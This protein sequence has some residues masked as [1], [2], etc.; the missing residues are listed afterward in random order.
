MAVTGLVVDQYTGLLKLVM[1]MAY[2][3]SVQIVNTSTQFP[4]S[5]HDGCSLTSEAVDAAS[6]RISPPPGKVR[7]TFSVTVPSQWTTILVNAANNVTNDKMKNSLD[8]MVQAANASSD[9]VSSILTDVGL[10]VED[11][12]QVSLSYPGPS[13][14][15]TP[16]MPTST[17]VPAPPSSSPNRYHFTQ[18]VKLE[19]TFPAEQVISMLP[20]FIRMLYARHLSMRNYAADILVEVKQGR[21]SGDVYEATITVL[22]NDASRANSLRESAKTITPAVMNSGLLEY[23]LNNVTLT[24][25][26]VSQPTAVSGD[27]GDSTESEIPWGIILGAVGA[28]LALAGG[29]GFAYFIWKKQHQTSA[30]MELDTI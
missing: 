15:P 24:F 22:S 28:V 3:R 9:S 7:V 29:C 11:P 2:A 8:I 6:R 21:R 26:S 16:G 20:Q 23:G 13:P 14:S 12:V 30:T 27:T 4:F 5:Y 18:V 19:T 17:P 10:E 1:E 25:T